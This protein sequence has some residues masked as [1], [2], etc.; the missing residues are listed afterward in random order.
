MEEAAYYAD[1]ILPVV[2]RPGDG[3]RLHA[4]RRPRHPLA[5]AGG[6]ARSASRSTDW[7]IWIDLAHAMAKARQEEPAGVLDRQLPRGVE[8]LPQALGDVRGEHA[9]HG[10][11]DQ[12]RMEKRAEPLR[13]PCPTASTPASARSTSTTPRG[14]RPPKALDPAN[15]GKRFLTPSGKV[16]IFTA[17]IDE[18]AGDRRPRAPCRSSTRTPK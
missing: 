11:H 15:K 16:E 12:A 14:T 10:R 5:E 13:W 8:G 17:E 2:Q 4:P 7:E 3:R 18:E 1:V 6:A 9:R